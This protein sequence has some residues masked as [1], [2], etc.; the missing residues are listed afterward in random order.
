MHEIKREIYSK[1]YL[2]RYAKNSL[3]RIFL[4]SWG[5]E[6]EWEVFF[7]KDFKIKF[8]VENEWDLFWYVIFFFSL[9]ASR[10]INIEHNISTLAL[11]PFCALLRMSHVMYVY[12]RVYVSLKYEE[13]QF[14]QQCRLFLEHTL[15]W[16]LLERWLLLIDMPLRVNNRMYIVHNIDLSFTA[17]ISI[18]EINLTLYRFFILLLFSNFKNE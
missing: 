16:I 3:K 15:D 14:I 4:S 5:S 18:T 9:E 10:R 7:Y 1:K 12:V 11:F 6:D 8:S 13:L 17:S 2:Y